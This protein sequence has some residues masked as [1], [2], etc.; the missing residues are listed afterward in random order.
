[1]RRSRRCPNSSRVRCSP[2]TSGSCRLARCDERASRLAR[3]HVGRCR[4][5][6]LGRCLRCSNL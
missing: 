4:G 1:M 6:G 3:A 2:R 5:Q